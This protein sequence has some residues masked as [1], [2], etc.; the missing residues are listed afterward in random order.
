MDVGYYDEVNKIIESD[1]VELR[2]TTCENSGRRK[3]LS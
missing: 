3:W 1:R 2:C